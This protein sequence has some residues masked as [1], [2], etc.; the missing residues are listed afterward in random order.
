[1]LVSIGDDRFGLAQADPGEAFGQGGC[2]SAVDINGFSCKCGHCE[3]QRQGQAGEYGLEI[4]DVAPELSSSRGLMFPA[5]KV[6][7]DSK[8]RNMGNQRQNS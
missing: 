3:R 1:M 7:T 8:N 6:S 4:H 5:W 2:V